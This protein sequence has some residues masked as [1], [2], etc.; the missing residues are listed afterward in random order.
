MVM[1]TQPDWRTL[2]DE[3][4]LDLRISDLRLRMKGPVAGCI[5]Q[6]YQELK[7]KNLALMP[8]CHIGDEWFCPEGCAAIFIPFYLFDDRLRKL[9]LQQILEVEGGTR[10]ECMKLL[11]H[12]A[13]H[14]YSY[15]YR[16]Q[17]KKKWQQW[18]GLSSQEYPETYRPRRYSKSYVIHLDDWYAQMHPDEDWAETFA[19]WLTPS[20]NWR[21]Q[22][23]GWPALR[24][25]EYVDELMGSLRDKEP[26]GLAP[27][28]ASYESSLRIKLK[29]YYR[30]KQKAYAESFTDLF[31]VDLHQLFPK[32]SASNGHV[33]AE[34]FLRQKR[35]N[36]VEVICRWTC[37][38]KYRVNEI[39]G[40]LIERARALDLA[41]DATD[42]EL[43]LQLVSYITSLVM[44]H[45]FTGRFR[46]TR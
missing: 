39:L 36:F 44:N 32:S 18:F 9:E 4:L 29:T 28:C 20:Q 22:Y 25:L 45:R 30:R 27:Y 12:E 46:H 14:A 38:P 7:E 1:T 37:E 5:A 43:P 34:K 16:L 11:R 19:V 35:R 42:S 23:D 2:E 10:E 26:V 33:P 41:A 3:A 17:R 40:D 6:L 13:G 21:D 15:A 31:D 8:P 24:K